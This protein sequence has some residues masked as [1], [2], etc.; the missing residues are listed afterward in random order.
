VG[1]VIPLGRGVAL[2]AGTAPAAFEPNAFVRIAPDSTVTVLVKHLE[3]GQ[4]PW[5]GLA[6]LVAE[7]LDADWSQ[8]RAE[9]APADVALYANTLFGVQGTGGSTAI[10]NSYLQMRKAGAAARAMLVAAAAER[11]GV[12]DET[13]RVE[14]GVL[15]GPGGET[16]V[17]G[18]LAEAAAGRPAPEDPPLKAPET[19]RLI[20]TKVP[21]LDT[22]PKTTGAAVYTMDV[23]RPGMVVAAVAHP[24]VIGATV[25][26]FDAT[27]ALALKGVRGVEAVPSGVAVYA[28]TTWHAFEGRRALEVEWDTSTGE[29]RSS[30]AMFRAY[31]DALEGG[32][33][34]ARRGD[35]AGQLAALPVEEAVFEFPFLAHAPMEPLDAVVEVRPDGAEAWL[36]CQFQTVDQAVIAAVLDLPPEK[37]AINTLLAGGSFGRRAQMGSPFAREAALVA[38]AWGKGPVKLVWSREDDITTG[39]YR[40][41]TVHRIRAALDAAGDIAVWEQRIANQS[42]FEGT[43]WEQIILE[44]GI[45]PT[46]VEGAADLPYAIPHFHVTFASM[47]SPVPPLWWRSVGHTHTAYATEAFIDELLEKG[48]R[49]PVEGRLRLLADAD[50]RF[51]GV[52]RRVAEIADWSG[53]D[54]KGGGKR[55]VALHKSFGTWVA[56]IM[57]VEIGDG[58]RPRVLKVWCAVDCGVAINPDVIVA[59]MEGGIGFGLGAILHDEVTLGEGGVVQQSNFHDYK[60]LRIDEMPAVEVAIV[61]STADPTGVGEP[62]VPPV[63]PALANAWRRLTGQSV[64]RLP[65]LTA[66]GA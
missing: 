16:A 22:P 51:A 34:A 33:D 48:G 14:R 6:T 60:S 4:G 46:S 57:D 2:A 58:G 26:S 18:E 31:R 8:M 41:L 37:V 59:Q 56:Q 12:A 44:E 36:G 23:T 7:E 3:M 15:T 52:L 49:D 35:A 19:F 25:A 13:I 38:K 17:F 28:D 30:E 5:T 20:G 62:G 11:W 65:F 1:T 54:A 9:H 21:K 53:V 32:K 66:V 24:R 10:A 55:G 27:K 42:I 61:P 45:D 50:P 39:W 47:K 29:T 40:P 43:D 63:G 64:R